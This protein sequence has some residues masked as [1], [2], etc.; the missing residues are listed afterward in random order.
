MLTRQ[1]ELSGQT[2]NLTRKIFCAEKRQKENPQYKH[3]VEMFLFFQT[4]TSE[5]TSFF[6][7]LTTMK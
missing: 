2:S 1:R 3:Q 6:F 4:Q 5:S 7:T